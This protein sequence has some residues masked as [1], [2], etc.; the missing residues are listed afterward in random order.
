VEGG[1]QYGGPSLMQVRIDGREMLIPFVPAICQAV[2][3]AGRTI[4]VDLPAGLLDL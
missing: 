1:Q 3:V 2:D 4:V